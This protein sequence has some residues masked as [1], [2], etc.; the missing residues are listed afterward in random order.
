MAVYSIA[1]VV[2]LSF[3]T[4]S[5]AA[6]AAAAAA[7]SCSTLSTSLPLPL[8][9]SELASRTLSLFIRSTLSFA[10]SLTRASSSRKITR[11][12][13]HLALFL[14][15]PLYSTPAVNSAAY[16]FPRLPDFSKNSLSLTVAEKKI[17][18]LKSTTTTTTT[19]IPT[20]STTPLQSTFPCENF[21][22]LQLK[23][24]LARFASY[25]AIP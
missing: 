10:R 7:P 23:F 21:P 20:T 18:K 1:V 14:C 13:H 16:P 3:S 9:A 25:N 6:A 12:D 4:V 22:I 2:P 24:L 5:R 15:C 17:S 11:E 8:A 19:I